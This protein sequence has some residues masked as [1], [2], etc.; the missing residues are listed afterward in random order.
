MFASL[1]RLVHHHP[2]LVTPAALGV[3][4]GVVKQFLN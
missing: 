2:H 1:T 3:R 4:D